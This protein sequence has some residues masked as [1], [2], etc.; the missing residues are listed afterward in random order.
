M[1]SADDQLCAKLHDTIFQEFKMYK[2]G[3]GIAFSIPFK[4][5]K[6]DLTEQQLQ[7]HPKNNYS[8]IL[9]IIDRGRS[10]ECINVARKA[11]VRGG[12]VV[13]A[14]GAGIPADFYFPLFIE[15][16]KDLVIILTQKEQ[17]QA[18]IKKLVTELGLEQP[19]VGILFELPVIR[20]SGLFENRGT[21]RAGG[22]S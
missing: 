16:Q 13:H 18:T 7:S 1:I 5:Y 2:R 12:T 8:C 11:G 4:Q 22:A 15:P 3:R 14:R 20:T 19:G 6:P 21:E 10:E 9:V 17:T